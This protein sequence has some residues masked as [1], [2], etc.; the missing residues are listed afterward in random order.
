[1]AASFTTAP[2]LAP[3]VARAARIDLN[4]RNTRD[5]FGAEVSLELDLD[6][7]EDQADDL[8]F[9]EII[10]KAVKGKDSPMPPPV[11]SAFVIPRPRAEKDDD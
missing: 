9:N 7:A 3:Y 10:W 6:E 4:A 5:A 2:D 1:M 11:R 8:V